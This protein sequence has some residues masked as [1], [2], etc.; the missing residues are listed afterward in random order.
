MPP[1]TSSSTCRRSAT[2]PLADELRGRVETLLA[3]IEDL[4]ESTRAHVERAELRDPEPET[5]DPATG[6]AGAEAPAAGARR[7]PAAPRQ[8]VTLLADNG[9]RLLKGGPV[10]AEVRTA[11]AADVAAFKEEHGYTPELA[12]VI[13]GRDAPSTVYL[14]KILDGCRL[15]GIQDRLVELCDDCTA[16][17]LGPRDHGPRA[18]SGR[19][20]GSSS[21]SRSPP[22]FPL[23]V[24]IDTLDPAKDIDGIHP[25]N[26]GLLALG[27]DG[28]LPATAHA[29]VELLKRSGVELAGKPAPSS[30]AAATSSA[31]RPRS[32]C[33]AS[34]PP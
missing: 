28:F 5:G 26:A 24:V 33:S 1:R 22:R 23:R 25:L 20:P 19:W 2:R 16:E 3:E 27:Y 8:P 34:T 21:S 10:A 17:A 31:S 18:P 13:V 9:P 32:C 14:H 30:S 29:A 4:A 7:P 6:N 11:V 15:V 12:V